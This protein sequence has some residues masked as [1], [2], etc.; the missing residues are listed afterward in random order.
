MTCHAYYMLKVIFKIITLLSLLQQKALLTHSGQY[1][2]SWGERTVGV[3]N[4]GYGSYPKLDSPL[5]MTKTV[6]CSRLW[7]V[8]YYAW[9]AKQTIN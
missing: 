7:E 3:L 1:C 4:H 5:V 2:S 8:S 9:E 6:P